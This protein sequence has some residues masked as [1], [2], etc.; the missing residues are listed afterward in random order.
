M[1]TYVVYFGSTFP[2]YLGEFKT[3]KA[4]MNFIETETNNDPLIC[5]DKVKKE[6]GIKEDYITSVMWQFGYEREQA[7]EYIKTASREIVNGIYER[8]TQNTAFI[9]SLN[10]K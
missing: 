1:Y 10:Q 3:E 8:Y 9:K 2:V 6:K 7:L 4:T 5:F